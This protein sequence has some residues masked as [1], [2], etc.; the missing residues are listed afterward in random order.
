MALAGTILVI[1]FLIAVVGPAI[2][3]GGLG[4]FA[5]VVVIFLVV[6][7]AERWVRSR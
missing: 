7:L 1:L 6:L 3:R 4:E 5:G 2:S